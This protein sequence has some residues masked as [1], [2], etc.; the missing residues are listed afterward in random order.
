[1]LRNRRCRNQKFRREYPIKP[2]TVDFCCVDLKLIIEVDGKQHQTDE[3]RQYDQ[4]RDQYL[5]SEGT[6]SCRSRVARPCK[7][8]L[9]CGTRSNM[10]LMHFCSTLPPHPQPF[11][12][13]TRASTTRSRRG[14]EGSQNERVRSHRTEKTRFLRAVGCIDLSEFANSVRRTLLKNSVQIRENCS[15]EMNL[16]RIPAAGGLLSVSRDRLRYRSEIASWTRER[17]R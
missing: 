16:Q 15:E 7:I 13:T 4:R 9:R 2:Y 5:P 14:G 3:G 1:M 10:Q 6:K 8:Q 12:P 11:S 17:V